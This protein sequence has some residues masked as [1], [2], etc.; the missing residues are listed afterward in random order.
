MFKKLIFGFSLFA[1]LLF[2][3]T[4]DDGLNALNKSDFQIAFTIFEDLA[5]KGDAKAQYYLGAMYMQRLGVK[6]NPKK[7]VEWWEKSANQGFAAAQTNLGY[8]YEKGSGG[9]KQDSKKAFEWYQKSALQGDVEAQY[10]FGVSYEK[11]IGATQDYAKA[12]EWYEKSANQGYANAQFN[13]GNMYGKGQGVKQ[14]YAKAFE[15]Y[16]KQQLK[17]IQGLKLILGLCISMG[18]V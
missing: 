13:L 18:K 1:T 17:E 3:A 7:A 2:G 4:F 15:L 9:L 6:W 11:G 8:M 10:N 5:L 14:D 16:E 12:V